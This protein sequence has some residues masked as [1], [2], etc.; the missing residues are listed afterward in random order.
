MHWAGSLGNVVV[1]G[2]LGRSRSELVGSHKKE[3][4]CLSM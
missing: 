1:V 3:S 2:S 4:I